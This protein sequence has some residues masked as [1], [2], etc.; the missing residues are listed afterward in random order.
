MDIGIFE[1]LIEQRREQV[2]ANFKVALNNAYNKGVV[3][4]ESNT[5][6]TRVDSC[7]K[8]MFPA[9]TLTGLLSNNPYSKVT[10]SSGKKLKSAWHNGFLVGIK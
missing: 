8:A 10:G 9:R 3:Y 6:D 4:G 7:G 5:V 1:E 2:V